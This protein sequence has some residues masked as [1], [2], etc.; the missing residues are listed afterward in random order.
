MVGSVARWCE[1]RH[2]ALMRERSR[3]DLAMQAGLAFVTS[4]TFFVAAAV[5]IPLRHNVVVV[6]ALGGFFL[7]L[8]VQ[9]AR[10]WGPLYGVP[11]AI[12]AGLAFDSFY[13][14]PI[15]DFGAG[16]WQNWLVIAIYIGLGVLIGTLGAQAQRRAEASERSRALLAK[17]QAGL[18]RVATLVARGA[19]P[20]EVFTAVAEEVGTLLGVDGA[21]VIRYDGEDE[22]IQLAGWRA[23]GFD[24][25]PVG[26][27][28]VQASSLSSEVL[29]TGRVVRIDGHRSADVR[30]GVGAPIIAQG[31]LW[32]AM[33][34]W[35]MH[36]EPLPASAEARLADFT[37]L[38]A[39]A[40]SNTASREELAR[41]AD[42]QAA[43]RRVAMLVAHGVPPEA[44]FSAIAQEV[45]RLLV[46]DM[47]EIARYETGGVVTGIASWV[48]AGEQAALA[49]RADLKG[50]NVTAM[51]MK[52]GR[53]ARMDSYDRASGP[54]AALMRDSGIR[55]SVG[56]P[57]VVNGRLWGV[58]IASS[59]DPLA[60]PPDT[61]SRIAAFT[62]LAAGAISNTE[63]RAELSSLV[64]EHA[65]LQRVATLVAQDVP[66]S[67][68]YGAVTEEVG[69]VLGTDLAA[70]FSYEDDDTVT[71]VATWSAMGSHPDVSGQ[72]PYQRGDLSATIAET[73]QP[74][75][76]D[77]W[78]H[79]SSPSAMVARDQLGLRS[80]VG[81]P[82]IVRGHLW[83]AL[84][85]HSTS[86][87]RLPA[88]SEQRLTNFAELVATAIANSQAR[89]QVRRLADEQAAL[90]RVATLV[91]RESS[92]AEVFA[93]VAEELGRLLGVDDT[94]MLCYEDGEVKVLAEWGS[95]P[96]PLPFGTRLALE[97]QSIV[98]RVLATRRA[99]RTEDYTT[100]NGTL[101]EIAA[102]QG[103]RTAVGSPIIVGGRVWGVLVAGSRQAADLAPDAEFRVG[104]FTELV[105]TAISNMEARRELAASRARIVAA[106]D[107]ERRHVVRDLHD[108]AQQRLVHTVMTLK[109]ARRALDDGGEA[110]PT[111][112][113]EA[114]EHA[115]SATAEL[116][117]LVHG[118]LPAVLTR[119]GLR[120]GLNALATR[121]PVPVENDVD[122]GRLPE[123]VEA[124]AYFV[125]AEALTNVAKHARASHVTVTARVQD[126]ALRLDVR[127]DGVGGAQIEGSGLVG[128]AD[129]LAALDGRLRIESPP[130]GGTLLAATIPLVE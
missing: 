77:D 64:D 121:M 14:P 72:W 57:I 120:A 126:G 10:R 47:T 73:G 111:L 41:L 71:V 78:D 93:A 101:A 54:I 81:T 88:D 32:G 90:R 7:Y 115:T 113:A 33:L 44:V 89:F 92:S 43:L 45:G 91:A 100:A 63:A 124:T 98:G 49:M 52:S 80:S 96:N 35:Q 61:E 130:E 42:E 106:A 65:A 118:I 6:V 11:L 87:R 127:D 117:E 107:E 128:I 56:A 53:P 79:L 3:F 97:G 82:I 67:D 51:V 85:V 84:V 103:I 66:P 26:R 99:A 95:H 86:E 29:R 102:R 31:R 122:T 17:E 83:G 129:R 38:I 30:A 12:A 8:I 2:D 36:P 59:R 4:A 60:L 75:R 116:R 27:A 15:R 94:K 34:A 76:L 62:G 19:S 70:M 18:R 114:L 20:D 1:D 22:V 28:S 58:T 5:A 109:L 123:Q 55:S 108:G 23:A 48:R 46:V 50:D 125:V 25:L 9:A 110:L 39:T 104:Q 37:E 21:Q 105:A 16:F 119:G 24:P 68:L 112:I 13:I 40:I 69:G 74:A